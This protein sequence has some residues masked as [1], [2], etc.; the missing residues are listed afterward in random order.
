M[1]NLMMKL[2]LKAQSLRDGEEGQDLVEYALLVA[3]IALACVVGVSHVA[4]AVNNVFS[5]ISASLATP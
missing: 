5:N 1:K 2:A 4:V 3:L